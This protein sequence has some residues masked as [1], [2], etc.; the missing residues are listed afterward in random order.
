MKST[1]N[2]CMASAVGGY[3]GGEAP[4]QAALLHP[5]RAFLDVSGVSENGYKPPGP[6]LHLIFLDICVSHRSL[7]YEQ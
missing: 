5:T 6:G 1:P 3:L 7:G 4:N 2:V